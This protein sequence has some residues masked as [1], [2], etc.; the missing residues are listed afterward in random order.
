M[1]PTKHLVAHRQRAQIA[2][3]QSTNLSRI[4]IRKGRKR[5]PTA[6]H[7]LLS[8]PAYQ[9]QVES[10]QL[11]R[12]SQMLSSH[13]NRSSK[14]SEPGNSP[15][16]RVHV[17]DGTQVVSYS[18]FSN[19]IITVLRSI[20]GAM[21]REPVRR[22]LLFLIDQSWLPTTS[23]VSQHNW[24]VKFIPVFRSQSL[25]Q[26]ICESPIRLFKELDKKLQSKKEAKIKHFG[27]D[28]REV[29]ETPEE[30][31]K[32]SMKTTRSSN[33]LASAAQQISLKSTLIKQDD[34]DNVAAAI[35][36]RAASLGNKSWA[37]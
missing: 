27:L 28:N 26:L 20:T 37:M 30:P 2:I 24:N 17:L 21:R 6:T 5:P 19:L 4:P 1:A 7:R 33:D 11:P 31:V 8:T 29:I 15:P 10:F 14:S 25:T 16:T 35:R 34:P 13:G 22:L 9:T 3:T 36:Q 32:A 12:P 18:W 23:K